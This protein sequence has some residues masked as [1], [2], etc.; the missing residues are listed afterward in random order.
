MRTSGKWL[1]KGAAEGGTSSSII[2]ALYT[3]GP[4]RLWLLCRHQGP[5]SFN[6]PLA[7][8]P[9]FPSVHRVPIFLPTDPYAPILPEYIISPWNNAN[10]TMSCWLQGLNTGLVNQPKTQWLPCCHRSH[11]FPLVSFAVSFFS[12]SVLCI[13]F[14][15]GKLLNQTGI[16]A[17]LSCLSCNI[18]QCGSFFNK[19]SQKW[20]TTTAL[21]LTYSTWK[22]TNKSDMF[23]GSSV[24]LR[25]VCI[26]SCYNFSIRHNCELWF[27]KREPC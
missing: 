8:L 27:S 7:L 19:K 22:E 15:E 6:F 13:Y 3:L 10:R 20:D 17:L 18:L 11:V 9:H 1:L 2:A 4:Q 21:F 23:H 5:S 24:T 14:W 12:L 26:Y 25:W 16:A